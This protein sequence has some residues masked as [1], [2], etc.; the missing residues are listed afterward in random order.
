[1][2]KQ[3]IR[4]EQYNHDGLQTVTTIIGVLTAVFILYNIWQAVF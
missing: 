4:K 3:E 2:K 1:M